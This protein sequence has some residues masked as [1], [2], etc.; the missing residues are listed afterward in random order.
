MF[1]ICV[2]LFL[3]GKYVYTHITGD[4]NLKTKDELI[5]ERV[6]FLKTVVDFNNTYYKD[7]NNKFIFYYSPK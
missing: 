2:S 7:V 3:L 4:R 5:K 6:S 1:Y